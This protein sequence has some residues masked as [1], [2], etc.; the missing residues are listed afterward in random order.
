MWSWPGKVIKAHAVNTYPNNL[1]NQ[2][3]VAKCD[4]IKIKLCEL[5][6]FVK[7][8]QGIKTNMYPC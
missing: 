1:A 2:I 4:V 8:I 3:R 5:M 7:N 6:G